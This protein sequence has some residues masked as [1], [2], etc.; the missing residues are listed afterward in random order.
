MSAPRFTVVVPGSGV[1]FG[2]LGALLGSIEKGL[3][4]LENITRGNVASRVVV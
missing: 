4:L 1:Y 2:S 3:E